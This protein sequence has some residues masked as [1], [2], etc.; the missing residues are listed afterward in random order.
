MLPYTETECTSEEETPPPTMEE[1][2]MQTVQ[3]EV[4]ASGE[5]QDVEAQT[6]PVMP[7]GINAFYVGNDLSEGQAISID[8]VIVVLYYSDGNIEEL[9][10]WTMIPAVQPLA[11]GDNVYQIEVQ[12]LMCQLVISAARVDGSVQTDYSGKTEVK[13]E[14]ESV[15]S[16]TIANSTKSKQDEVDESQDETQEETITVEGIAVYWVGGDCFEGDYV[17]Q[18]DIE[19]DVYYSDGSVEQNVQGWYCKEVGHQLKKGENF[20]TIYYQSEVEQLSVTGE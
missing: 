10:E 2:V 11:A 17:S 4:I 19:V 14:E 7:M 3:H 5:E 8:D 20:L 6:M 16:E 12:D 18:D 15:R 1:E 9:N 13:R